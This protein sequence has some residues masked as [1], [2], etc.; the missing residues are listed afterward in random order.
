MV[1]KIGL[2]ITRHEKA[3]RALIGRSEPSGLAGRLMAL[4]VLASLSSVSIPVAEE[5]AGFN[6]VEPANVLMLLSSLSSL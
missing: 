6:P 4:L 3:A 2:C 1:Q 5:I